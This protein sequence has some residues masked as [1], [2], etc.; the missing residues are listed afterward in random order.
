MKG[1]PPVES[2][3]WASARA[4]VRAAMNVRKRARYDA[5]NELHAEAHDRTGSEF[6]FI[7]EEILRGDFDAIG[8][9]ELMEFH[10][11]FLNEYSDQY[12]ASIQD[13]RTFVHSL[14][15][16][17]TDEFGIETKTERGKAYIVTV[18][19]RFAE[20]YEEFANRTQL[21]DLIQLLSDMRADPKRTVQN[22]VGKMLA[23]SE[24]LTTSVRERSA[25]DLERIQENLYRV[26]NWLAP[27]NDRSSP[28]HNRI[29]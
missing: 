17:E 13:P 5:V 28:A 20:K 25:Q 4:E 14:Y 11:L 18:D 8:G 12:A 9:E 16:V 6:G 21:G 22:R 23:D 10:N 3:A 15:D 19:A 26:T 2:E 1:V 7:L 29:N 24:Y 27:L